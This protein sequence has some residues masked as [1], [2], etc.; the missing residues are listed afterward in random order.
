MFRTSYLREVRKEKYERSDTSMAGFSDQGLES[1]QEFNE[2]FTQYVNRARVLEQRNAVFRKQLEN[3]RQIEELS[4]QECA[5]TGQ[6]DENQQRIRQL[7][8]DLNRLEK[9]LK[10]TQCALDEYRTKYKNEREYDEQ[11]WDALESLIKD[12]NDALLKNLELQ[13]HILF[14]QQ[15]MNSTGVRNKKNLA[16]IQVYMTV[17]KHIHQPTTCVSSTTLSCEEGELV[18]EKRESLT[19]YQ[20]DDYKSGLSQLQSQT[21]KLQVETAQ[22]EQTIKSVQENYLDQMQSYNEQ[23]ENLR[24]EMEEAEKNLET[25]TNECQQVVMHQQSLENELERYK[26]IIENEDYRLQSTQTAPWSTSHR[27]EYAQVTP[28][29]GDVTLAMQGITSIK[30]RQKGLSRRVVKKKKVASLDVTDGDGDDQDKECM[31]KPSETSADGKVSVKNEEEDDREEED[32][33]GEFESEEGEQDIRQDDMP[34]GAQISRIYDALCNMVRDSMRR[35]RRPELPVA[36]FY[37]KGHYVLVTGEASYMDPF[38]CTSAPSR[39]QVI[40]TFDVGMDS[41]PQPEEPKPLKY[42]GNGDGDKG[43]DPTKERDK[44]KSGDEKQDDRKSGDNGEPKTPTISPPI[45][46]PPPTPSL[47]DPSQISDYTPTPFSGPS[48]PCPDPNAP[49]KWTSKYGDKQQGDEDRDRII[50]PPQPPSPDKL[51]EEPKYS[52]YEKIEMVE[53]VEM[54]TDNKLQAYE[55]TSTIVETTVEETSKETRAKRS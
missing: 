41:K 4:G 48:M 47:P 25:C 51:T 14:L 3:L 9:E 19:K 46:P 24:K 44:D 33:E 22:L 45:P 34:D 1:L 35:H 26:R 8:N 12:A 13:I 40:V 55:E 17:L 11:F 20:S 50:I 49:D 37:T 7:Y 29:S 6:I 27:Y 54:F 38:F 2:R 23:I 16:E 36:E 39:S 53:A 30:S 18:A 15:D 28:E 32:E 42:D 43:F 10:D 21:Q 5:F 31:R 52:Y